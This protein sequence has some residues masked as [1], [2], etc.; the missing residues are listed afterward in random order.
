M[1]FRSMLQLS[2]SSLLAMD[3]DRIVTSTETFDPDGQVVRST[4]TT[5]ETQDTTE[6]N[7]NGVSVA[8]NL[9]D[10]SDQGAAGRNASRQNKTEETVNYEIGKSVRTVAREQPRLERLSVAV[11]VDGI[12]TVGADGK[13][14]LDEHEIALCRA[15]GQR[16]ATTAKALETTRG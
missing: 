15:L 4:Q 13:R 6:A 12:E 7:S 2:E 10:G 1:L 16:L 3:F 8:N 14:D 11:M 5:N 9:P